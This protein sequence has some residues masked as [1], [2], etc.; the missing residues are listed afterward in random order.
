MNKKIV[1]IE[2]LF[3]SSLGSSQK[4]KWYLRNNINLINNISSIWLDL[5]IAAI[6]K[7]KRREILSDF[8]T[9]RILGI[10]KRQRPDL[11]KILVS[12]PS[13]RLWLGNQ[14]AGFRRK[15]L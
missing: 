1:D 11:Y 3:L 2:S 14:I 6:P 10:L 8:N 12:D 9:D 7:Y 15:F 4:L 5:T 13:G